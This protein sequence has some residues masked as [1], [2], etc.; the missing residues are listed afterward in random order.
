MFFFFRDLFPFLAQLGANVPVVKDIL[1]MPVVAKVQLI[2][3]TLFPSFFLNFCFIQSFC[4]LQL[5]LQFE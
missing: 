4:A 1:Q 5:L 2:I 3:N